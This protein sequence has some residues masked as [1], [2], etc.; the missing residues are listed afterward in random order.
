MHYLSIETLLAKFIL[1]EPSDRPSSYIHHTESADFAYDIRTNHDTDGFEA[2]IISHTNPI[3][4]ETTA[5]HPFNAVEF[6]L[7]FANEQYRNMFGL[8][9][10]LFNLV[11]KYTKK[12]YRRTNA[13]HSAEMDGHI[14]IIN[15]LL[16]DVPNTSID[17]FQ[18]SL[19]S[20]LVDDH[21]E[22]LKALTMKDMGGNS[23]NVQCRNFITNN[24]VDYLQEYIH[25]QSVQANYHLL[26]EYF[27]MLPACTRYVYLDTTTYPTNLLHA[28]F[29]QLDNYVGETEYLTNYRDSSNMRGTLKA[30]EMVKVKMN[31]Q[32]LERPVKI[33]TSRQIKQGEPYN[34]IMILQPN[35]LD[36]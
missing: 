36:W 18:S 14:A 1:D 25:S 27:Y 34:Y 8:I 33:T 4:N 19:L 24:V 11:V 15:D 20:L 28:T 35:K 30:F 7:L 29:N 22:P 16:T 5:S 13:Y 23:E 12:T 3:T 26:D 6:E 21:L 17:E 9:E 31:N 32:L 10:H 2:I